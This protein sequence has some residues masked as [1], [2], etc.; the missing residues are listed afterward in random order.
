MPSFCVSCVVWEYYT[1]CLLSNGGCKVSQSIAALETT[2]STHT[3]LTFH[4]S[5]RSNDC[6]QPPLVD[7]NRSAKLSLGILCGPVKDYEPA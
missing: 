3:N 2:A 5:K 7:G 4:N 1:I 6:V